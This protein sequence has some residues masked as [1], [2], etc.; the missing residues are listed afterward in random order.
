MIFTLRLMSVV[1]L[2]YFYAW[3]KQLP[4][5]L[6]WRLCVH[7]SHSKQSMEDKKVNLC[8]KWSPN[9]LVIQQPMS[10]S[11]NLP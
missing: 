9:A 11:L 4:Y 5:P 7:S 8:Y 1:S 10:Y 6:T 3:E 2:T